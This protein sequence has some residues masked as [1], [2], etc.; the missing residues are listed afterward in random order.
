MI[1]MVAK[2]SIFIEANIIILKLGNI[3][4]GLLFLMS[5]FFFN[6]KKNIV[7][8]ELNT[9]HPIRKVV[10]IGGIFIPTHILLMLPPIIKPILKD[11]LKIGFKILFV[12]CSIM[13]TWVNIFGA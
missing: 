2:I 11:D 13:A 1:P 4:A 5:Y 10:N 7:I 9:K 3:N 12:F 8:V 6:P